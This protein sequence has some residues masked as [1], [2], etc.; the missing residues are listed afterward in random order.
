MVRAKDLLL[1]GRLVSGT[2]AAAM[3]LVTMAVPHAELRARTLELAGQVVSN[4]PLVIAKMKEL[5]AIAGT[6]E[7][8]DGIALEH[9]VVV[10]YATT[11]HDAT[12][13]L[14]SFLERRPPE[15][16]GR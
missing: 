10:E 12:E 13:G 2:E 3:G 1:T 11:S 4:S 9:E 6:H 7:L 15:W 14:H 8:G 16:K 5:Q